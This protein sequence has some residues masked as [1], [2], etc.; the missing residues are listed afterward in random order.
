MAMVA[1]QLMMAPMTLDPANLPNDID[2]LKALLGAVH[3]AKLQ[4]DK[5]AEKAEARA[6]DLDGLVA[7]LKLTIAKMRHDKFGASSERGAKLID[8]LELQLADLVE[9]ATE[10]KVAAAI[11][12]SAPAPERPLCTSC[13]SV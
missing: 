9:T 3:V 8:Q 6:L 2:T 13:S 5:R 12:S 7:H 10:G 4:S 11:T 1:K